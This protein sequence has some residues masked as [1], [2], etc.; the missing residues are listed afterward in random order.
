MSIKIKISKKPVNFIRAIKVLENRLLKIKDN[1]ASEMIW[2]LEHPETYTAGTN[3]KNSEIL[4]KRI[5]LY[6]TNRGGKI[7]YHGPGQIIFY[8]LI[9]LNKRKKDIRWFVR[10]LE[11][12][13]IE[14]LKLY[15]IK[16]IADR[17]NI[18]IWVKHNNRKKKVAAIG[19]KIKNW[20]AYHG[21]SLNYSVKLKNYKKIIPCGLVNKEMVNLTDLKKNQFKN[22][23]IN[24]VKKFIKNLET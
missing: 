16:S 17:N 22:I 2:I 24:L 18:G 11:N 3:F 8:F 9:N 5:K 7:T 4:D 20:I 21:F 15:K 1:K 19:L 10:V 14:T 23:Q 12:T 6:K 13:I